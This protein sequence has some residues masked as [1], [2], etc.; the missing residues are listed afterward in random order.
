VRDE[1]ITSVI[2]RLASGASRL[3][4]R[5]TRCAGFGLDPPSAEPLARIEV[6]VSTP[7]QNL[8]VPP[9]ENLTDR[10]GDEPQFVVPS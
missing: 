1:A 9:G 7:V 8:T 6:M 3:S 2:V 4:L 10:R 5:S